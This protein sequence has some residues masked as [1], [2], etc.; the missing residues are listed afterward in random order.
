MQSAF[1]L[2]KRDIS[3]GDLVR[4][5]PLYTM[6]HPDPR[7]QAGVVVGTGKSGNVCIYWPAIG[8]VEWWSNE[9]M[10]SIDED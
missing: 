5:N 3:Q 1:L 10:E 2:N 4:L 7:C 9:V 6:I 8:D